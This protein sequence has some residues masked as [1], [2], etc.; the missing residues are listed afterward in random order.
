MP[1]ISGAHLKK[2]MNGLT[3]VVILLNAFFLFLIVYIMFETTTDT[4]TNFIA[5]LNAIAALILMICAVV[6]L[7]VDG[8][9]KSLLYFLGAI[10][11]ILS[12]VFSAINVY[13]IYVFTLNII[14]LMLHFV[15]FYFI[16]LFII[17]K[18]KQDEIDF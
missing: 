12:D 13:Y 7:S 1:L 8:S 3:A 10:T 5:I 6:Y 18:V 11:L 9:K 4:I 14:D 2:V 17:E 16:Y 15:G